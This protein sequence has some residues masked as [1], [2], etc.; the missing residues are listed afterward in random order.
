MN[1]SSNRKSRFF[2]ILSIDGG[3]VRGIIPAAILVELEQL[4][5]QKS[6]NSEL[7]VSDFFDMIAGTSTGG[8]LTVLLLAPGDNG[9]ARYSAKDALEFYEGKIQTIFYRSYTQSISHAWGWT[10]PEYS[11]ANLDNLLKSYSCDMR[12]SQLRRAAL[13]T[14]FDITHGKP[15]FFTNVPKVAEK[16]QRQQDDDYLLCDVARA[17]SAAPTYFPPARISPIGSQETLSLV[18]GGVFAN[19]PTLCAY[20]EAR[21]ISYAGFNMPSAA[22]MFVLS[23]SCGTQKARVD[24][25]VAANWGALKWASPLI[26]IMMTGQ[27]QTTHY[28][29]TQIFDAVHRPSNYVR[30]DTPLHGASDALDDAS[31]ANIAKLKA[32]VKSFLADANAQQALQNAVDHLLQQ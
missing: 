8:I 2:R 27:S 7:K 5:Q 26:D 15:H 18:D 20:A 31:P 19:N 29:L 23:L 22:D 30:L 21:A 10:G 13:I 32:D 6:G 16:R 17:T 1:I 14:S 25:S 9:S 4:L 12:L 24:P 3:G 28:Q 11:P